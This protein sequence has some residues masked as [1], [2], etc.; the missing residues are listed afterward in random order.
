[1]SFDTPAAN[2]AFAKKFDFDFPLLCD[3]DRKVGL[4]YGACDSPTAG[5]ARRIGVVVDAEGK[6]KEYLPKVD[7]SAYPDQ[8]LGRI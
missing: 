3:T 8:V 6:V 1:V 2:Q 5:N 4:A 7:P